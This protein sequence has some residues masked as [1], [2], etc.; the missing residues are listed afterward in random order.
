MIGELP[1]PVTV[2]VPGTPV[3]LV[4]GTS[5]AGSR[6][7]LIHGILIQALPDNTG[8]IY[9][10]PSTVVGASRSNVRAILAIPTDQFIPSYSASLTLAPN[11]MNLNDFYIDAD[12]ADDGVIVSFLIL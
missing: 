1:A 10:G 5:Y 9:I 7:T 8:R 3:Q 12:D 6:P 2:P 4:V 11:A